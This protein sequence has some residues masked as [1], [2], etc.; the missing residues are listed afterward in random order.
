MEA[1]MKRVASFGEP[2]LSLFAPAEMAALLSEAGFASFEDLGPYEI[3]S[4][5]KYLSPP[6]LGTP[7]GHVVHARNGV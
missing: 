7:G 6:R 5:L 2:W 3:A 4:R 1:R